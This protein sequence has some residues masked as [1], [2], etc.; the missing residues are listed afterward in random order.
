M[1]QSNKESLLPPDAQNPAEQRTVTKILFALSFSH[2]VNDTIQALLPSIYPLLKKSFDLNFA[3]IGLITLVYQCVASLLQPFVGIYTDRKPKP[4][5]LALGMS[6][7]LV[8]IVMVAFSNSFHML[9]F[10][11]A[12]VGAG[13]SVFHPEA[14]RVAHMAAGQ[15][16]GF[17]QAV[18]QVGGNFGTSLGPLMAAWIIVPNGQHATAWFGILAL[19]GILVLARVGGWYAKNLT[20]GKVSKKALQ[21]AV[22]LPRHRVHLAVIVLVILVFSKYVYLVSLTNYYTFYLIHHFGVSVQESQ[23]YLFLFLFAVALGT[24]LGGPIGDRFGRKYVIWF[25]IFG[26]APFSL[27]LPHVGLTATAVLSFIIGVVLASAFSAIIVYAQELIPGKVGLIAGM[28]FGFAFGISGIAASALGFIADKTSIE[29]VF[30]FCAYLPLIGVIAIFLPNLRK[31]QK[32]A[33]TVA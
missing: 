11:A 2:A 31:M 33:Q 15:R 22:H 24:I 32:V 10:A 18:F 25:S 19:M 5:S 23:L 30:T 3:Q 14:S 21:V 4:Y 16:H 7:T 28:F 17:A 8:G 20:R 1:S 6:F 26:V 12:L 9:L 27:I 13:S 29:Q